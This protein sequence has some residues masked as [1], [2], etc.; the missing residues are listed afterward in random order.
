MRTVQANGVN[1]EKEERINSTHCN[2]SKHPATVTI[3]AGAVVLSTSPQDSRHDE[4]VRSHFDSCQG[5][6][7]RWMFWIAPSRLLGTGYFNANAVMPAEF[8]QAATSFPSLVIAQIL[9]ATC[10]CRSCSWCRWYSF[11]NFRIWRFTQ[12]AHCQVAIRGCGYCGSESPSLQIPGRD[13]PSSRTT[14]ARH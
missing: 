4:T 5:S 11:F 8:S 14:G 7:T 2:L 10:L 13:S 12:A 6:K 9:V 3:N 1:F